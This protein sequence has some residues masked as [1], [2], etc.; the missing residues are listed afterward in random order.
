MQ[1]PCAKVFLMLKVRWLLFAL[2]GSVLLSP[3]WLR[4][5]DPSSSTEIKIVAENEE[6]IENIFR[7][8]GNVRIEY[9]EL[10][11]FADWVEIDTDTKDV[12]ARG[13]PVTLHLPGETISM[14][15]L[16][17]NL[18]STEGI[19]EKVRGQMQPSVTWAAD[20]AERVNRDLYHM[21][22]AWFTSCSQATPRWRFTSSRANLKKGDYLEMWNSVI[23]LKKVPVFYLPYFRYPL[24]EERST[25]LLMPAAGY[26]G[27]KGFVFS[28][29]FYWAMRRN[30]DATFNLDYFSERGLG[31]AAEYRYILPRGIGGQIQLYYFRFKDESLYNTKN[32]YI[33]R[34]NHN[35]PL[36]FD[37][38]LVADVDW[39]SSFDF[40]R[41]F[42][43]NFKR[44]TVSN[45]SSQVYLSRSW[46]YFNW[47]VRVSRFE[48][49]YRD[50]DRSIIRLNLPEA[51]F[52]ASRIKLISP[53]YFSF[54]T[55]FNSWEYGWDDEYA[56]DKQRKSQSFAFRPSL[57][58]P[59]TSIPWMTLNASFTA[60]LDYYFQS[61][62]PGSNEVVNEPLFTQS[63]SSSLELLGPVFVKVFY[64][65]DGQPKV[66][67]VL[68]PTLNFVYDS[69][70]FASD[71][72]ITPRFYIRDYYLFYGVT[73]NFMVKEESGSRSLI[74]LGLGQRYFFDPAT[75]PLQNYEV[76]GKIPEFSDFQGN[77][78]Y[79][80]VPGYSLDFTAGF[81]PY[82]NKFSRL[83]LGLNLGTPADNL[84]LRVNWYKSTDPF[85]EEATF[86]R[87][88]IG[89]YTGIKIPRWS[90]DTLVQLDYNIQEKELLYSALSMVYHYQCID[91][92]ADLRVF[93]FRDTPEMQFSFSFELGNIGR[94]TDFLGGLGF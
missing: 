44:A 22:R 34:F 49:Y 54:N 31:A 82:E 47:N 73:N 33:V 74:T 70:V 71:R 27:Q 1:G 78:R 53:L 85:K 50:R 58:L 91:F 3:G 32:S 17:G 36:P 20:Q 92:R 35:Q 29:S 77:F 52:T 65:K 30:M 69:P 56:E 83:R 64:G 72:I 51:G 81:N 4:G 11:L 79:Y 84:F 66:K 18:D 10:T 23:Y 12:L 7:A 2:A 48:T 68:E 75:S 89:F 16:Q 46:S 28:Q 63:H 86:A 13:D 88:Q 94:S 67:H 90:L 76:D 60:N 59:F 15:E 25:G 45:R 43:N 38:R 19:L 9:K 62:A 5:Q 21:E 41:E 87:H 55:A 61:Y 14:E 37:F 80:P 6:R 39:Q 8:W 26:N 40:L 24:D 57:F 42:D 93:Y